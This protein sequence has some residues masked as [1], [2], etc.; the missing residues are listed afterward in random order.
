[1]IGKKVGTNLYIHSSMIYTLPEEVRDYISELKALFFMEKWGKDFNIVKYDVKTNDVSFIFSPDFDTSDEPL[2]DIVYNIKNKHLAKIIDYTTRD[3]AK[4]QIYHH[5]WTM[6][7]EDYEG[8]DVKNS[9]NRSD[10]WENHPVV[11]ERKK[12]DKTFK[13][14]IGMYGYWKELMT[15]IKKYDGGEYGYSIT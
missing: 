12:N 13:S 7:G 2:V 1:M 8:F 10:W 9:K 5:K 11:L 3:E 15:E 4:R 14:R 6:V